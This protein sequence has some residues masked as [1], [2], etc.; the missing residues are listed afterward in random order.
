[1]AQAPTDLKITGVTAA[2]DTGVITASQASIQLSENG[3]EIGARFEIYFGPVNEMKQILPSSRP[4]IPWEFYP[5]IGQ[6]TAVW[7]SFEVRLDLVIGWLI[8]ETGKTLNHDPTRLNFRKR[9]ELCKDLIL[10]RF[11]ASPAIP[12]FLTDVLSDAA[13]LHWRRNLI[14]HGAI[15]MVCEFVNVAP[16]RLRFMLRAEGR[17]NGKNLSQDYSFDNLEN[18]YYKIAHLHGRLDFVVGREVDNPLLSSQDRQTLREF[19]ENNLPSLP[20]PP[21]P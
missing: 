2:V 17:H 6:I 18:L 12:K 1:M 7:G 8:K 3:K 19:A 10:L 20:T 9:K 21:M 13:D 4:P 11:G 16:P 5:I 14:V 15:S